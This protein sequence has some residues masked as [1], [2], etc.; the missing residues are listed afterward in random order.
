M[1]LTCCSSV[2]SEDTISPLILARTADILAALGA[3]IFELTLEKEDI[4][5]EW[6]DANVTPI[7]KTVVAQ[8]PARVF[9]RLS[10][11]EHVEDH[12]PGSKY[13]PSGKQHHHQEPTWYSRLTIWH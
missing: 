7:F 1:R 4:P 8:T 3:H 9:D 10:M 12:L 11:Q 5:D 2:G 6:R 13:T